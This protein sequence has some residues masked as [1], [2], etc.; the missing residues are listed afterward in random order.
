MTQIGDLD[1]RVALQ[2]QTRTPDGMGGFSVAWVTAGTVWAAVWPVSASE[3][4]KAGAT[5]MVATHRIRIRYR[6]IKASWRV[7]YNGRYFS[8]VSI[9]D[10]NEAHEWLDLLCKEVVA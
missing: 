5:T 10:P 8:V 9:T 1:K 4:V 6:L 2:Y 7:L 3:Q